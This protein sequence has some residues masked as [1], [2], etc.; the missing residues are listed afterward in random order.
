MRWFMI[1]KFIEFESARRAVAV[2]NVTAA[3]EATNGYLP[4]FPVYPPSLI[5]EGVAQTGGLLV[6]EVNRYEEHVVLAKVSH[7]RFHQVVRPGDTLTY[8]AVIQDVKEGGAVVN[9]TSHIGDRL[10]GEIEL[11]FA[12]L[13][14][15][16][17]GTR[18]FVPADFVRML[19]ALGIYEVGRDQH[20]DPLKVP[21]YL[22]AAENAENAVDPPA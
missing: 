12:H 17:D 16:F 7:A 21:E 13:D 20:G 5:V 8:T 18:L 15:R 1:D 4:G 2:K 6:G 14:D 10:Q 19:R 11:I 9:G 22:L 3:E